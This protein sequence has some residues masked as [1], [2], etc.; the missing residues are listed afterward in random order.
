MCIDHIRIVIMQ[1]QFKYILSYGTILNVTM[2]SVVNVTIDNMLW[3]PARL[4]LVFFLCFLLSNG[5]VSD[6]ILISDKDN[7]SKY[8]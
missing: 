8:K 7:L 6:Q 5:N 4:L 2:V 1:P 3:S